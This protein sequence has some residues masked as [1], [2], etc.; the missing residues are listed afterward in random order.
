MNN[1]C[2][3]SVSR[4][5]EASAQFLWIAHLALSALTELVGKNSHDLFLAAVAQQRVVQHNPLVLPESIPAACVGE[6]S[7]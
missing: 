1:E 4:E 2:D 7:T 6:G 5:R 3:Q